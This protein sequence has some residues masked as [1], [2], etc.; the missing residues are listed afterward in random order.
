VRIFHSEYFQGELKEFLRKNPDYIKRIKK[1]L[2]FMEFDVRHPSLRLHKLSNM[3]FYSVSVD[4]KIR[5]VF[6]KDGDKLFLI[7][8][9]N[10]NEVY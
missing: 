4:M 1:T 9:G 2:Y 7:K 5:I 6:R 8:I 3:E 10:H